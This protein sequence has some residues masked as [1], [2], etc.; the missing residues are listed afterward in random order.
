MTDSTDAVRNLTVGMVAERWG[1]SDTFVY[2]EINR[3][4]L[5][6]FKLGKKLLRVKPEWIDEYETGAGRDAPPL[7]ED[8]PTKPDKPSPAEVGRIVRLGR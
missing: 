8:P 5:K 6:A 4:R 1:V 3:G 2:D 7:P